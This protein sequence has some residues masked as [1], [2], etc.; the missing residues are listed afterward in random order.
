MQ[1]RRVVSQMSLWPVVYWQLP[2]SLRTRVND[3]RTGKCVVD[4]VLCF[5]G[6]T[7]YLLATMSLR[8]RLAAAGSDWPK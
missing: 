5:H 2:T 4:L 8:R 3:F 1:T 6:Q 7:K